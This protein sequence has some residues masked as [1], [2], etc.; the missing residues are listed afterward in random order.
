MVKRDEETQLPGMHDHAEKS[1]W[2]GLGDLP[3]WIW[4]G[5]SLRLRADQTF[6]I[7]RRSE[8]CPARAAD[9]L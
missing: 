7:L 6:A 8:S 5:W 2:L 4:V 9:L 3:A 1:W